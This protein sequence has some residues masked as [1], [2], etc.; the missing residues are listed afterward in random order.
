MENYEGE[1]KNYIKEISQLNQVIKT[2]EE[3]NKKIADVEKKIRILK[4][5]HEKEIKEIEAYYKEK[6]NYLTKKLMQA[7]ACN[8]PSI[9]SKDKSYKTIEEKEFIKKSVIY[10]FKK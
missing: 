7:K 9:R 8:S 6:I 5:K 10:F 3:H 2:Y 4:V 1:I